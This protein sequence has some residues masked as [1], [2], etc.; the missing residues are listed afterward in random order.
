MFWETKRRK[1]GRFK[2]YTTYDVVWSQTRSGPTWLNLESRSLSTGKR[3]FLFDT[4]ELRIGRRPSHGETPGQGSQPVVFL[5]S[6]PPSRVCVCF[7][8]NCVFTR[9]IATPLGYVHV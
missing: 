1:G 9:S 3:G 8:S 5:L 2:G 4:L 6:R 7:E